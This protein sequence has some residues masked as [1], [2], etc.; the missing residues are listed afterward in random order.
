MLTVEQT[1]NEAADE[2]C[3][4]E[5]EKWLLKKV[6]GQ[7]YADLNYPS[8]ST[9]DD[10]DRITE[11]EIFRIDKKKR[12]SSPPAPAENAAHHR[13]IESLAP[14]PA[15]TDRH[16]EEVQVSLDKKKRFK[17]LKAVSDGDRVVLSGIELE[18]RLR[19]QFMKLNGESSWANILDQDK[20]KLE[21][22]EIAEECKL[23]SYTLSDVKM[24]TIWPF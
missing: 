20:R 18:A 4:D 11:K 21:E 8:D 7:L 19:K 22:D 15:W 2:L 12:I 23:A 3:S 14:K 13:S 17:K 5:E 24:I 16:D 1:K 9:V 6:F 10:Q